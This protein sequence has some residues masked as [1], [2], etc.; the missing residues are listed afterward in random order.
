MAKPFQLAHKRATTLLV[1]CVV[2]TTA[3]SGSN[4]D[5]MPAQTVT[6]TATASSEPSPGTTSQPTVAPS[7][8][9]EPDSES[10]AVQPTISF[11]TVDP[12]GSITVGGFVIGVAEDDKE[13]LFAL[14]ARSSDARV[15]AT[16]LGL[17]NQD[18][19]ACGSTTLADPRLSR[20]AWDVTLTYTTGGATVTSDPVLLEIP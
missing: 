8:E 12:D 7:Q 9:P 16:T 6:A 19:T 14:E 13:C 2:L 4:S 11:A 18:T 10:F 3:C 5:P 1:A 15:T 20:G 17:T